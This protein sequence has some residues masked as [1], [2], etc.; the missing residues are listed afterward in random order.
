MPSS[1]DADDYANC[2]LVSEP[3]AS[4]S[5]SSDGLEKAGDGRDGGCQ[6]TVRVTGGSTRSGDVSFHCLRWLLKRQ[7]ERKMFVY[8]LLKFLESNSL[9][10]SFILIM[11]TAS[12]RSRGVCRPFNFIIVRRN[13]AAL[14]QPINS[15]SKRA[16][17]NNSWRGAANVSMETFIVQK[18]LNKHA[19]ALQTPR[20]TAPLNRSEHS[21]RLKL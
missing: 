4:A 21:E 14:L 16:W 9:R 19:S 12:K 6:R 15:A 2:A 10:L 3:D 5:D 18:R 11:K 1:P 13:S 7:N 8:R 20:S 17:R